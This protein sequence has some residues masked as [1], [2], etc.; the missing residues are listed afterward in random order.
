LELALDLLQPKAFV[1]YDMVEVSIKRVFFR[2][3]QI[4]K[5][6][7]GNVDSSVKVPVK[8]AVPH[9]MAKKPPHF[10]LAV[11]LKPGSGKPGV[12]LYFSQI[13]YKGCC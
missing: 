11:R 7:G 4:L 10:L 1:R 12:P 5:L 9:S 2:N 6:A 13:V 8:R 3:R